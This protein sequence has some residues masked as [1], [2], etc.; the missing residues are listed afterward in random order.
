[1]LQNILDSYQDKAQDTIKVEKKKVRKDPN[2]Q[3]RSSKF[4]SSLQQ[5]LFMNQSA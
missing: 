3:R 5:L 4:S 2:K 1:M